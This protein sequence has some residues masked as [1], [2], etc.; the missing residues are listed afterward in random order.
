MF[1]FDHTAFEIK[2]MKKLNKKATELKTN[3]QFG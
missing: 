2:K 1:F 3:E